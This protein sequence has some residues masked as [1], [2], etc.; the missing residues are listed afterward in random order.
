[1]TAHLSQSFS[2]T[3]F[4]VLRLH[5]DLLCCLS[6]PCALSVLHPQEKPRL[7]MFIFPALFRLRY[8]YDYKHSA[9]LWFYTCDNRITLGVPFC[10]SQH[11]LRFIPVAVFL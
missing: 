5:T 1:M 10:S 2:L 8:V 4:L 11:A 9:V 6:N 7:K 3:S